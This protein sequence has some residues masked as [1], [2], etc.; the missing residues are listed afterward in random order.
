MKW[1]LIIGGIAAAWF[2]LTLRPIDFKSPAC[3]SLAV[4]ARAENESIQ[5]DIAIARAGGVVNGIRG[6][7]AV[8]HLQLRMTQVEADLARV[9][10]NA[11]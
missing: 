6:A 3:Q 1:V 4:W 8:Q 7:A 5:R 11:C 9:E 2:A 10:H